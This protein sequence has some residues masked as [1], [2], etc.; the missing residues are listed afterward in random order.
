MARAALERREI[1]Q[2]LVEEIS[3]VLKSSLHMG[4]YR[5]VAERLPRDLIFKA[6]AEIK[7]DPPSE[8][9]D[10]VLYF[11]SEMNRAARELGVELPP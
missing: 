3:A 1:E 10:P 7:A 8:I 9:G 6:L 2:Y 5:A 11:F 4:F